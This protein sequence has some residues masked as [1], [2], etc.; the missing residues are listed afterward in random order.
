M[1]PSKELT[2][3]N[4][5]FEDDTSG[6]WEYIMIKQDEKK[7][8]EDE[9]NGDDD[10][11]D[12]GDKNERLEEEVLDMPPPWSPKLFVNKDKYAE[13]CSKGEKA[14]LYKKC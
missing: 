13:L 12:E 10:D 3:L 4:M 2:E 9:D 5:D 14:V 7:D 8:D 11:Y 6:E 1:D